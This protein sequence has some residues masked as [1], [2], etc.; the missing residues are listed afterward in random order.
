MRQHVIKIGQA[1]YLELNKR[2]S[3]IR[4]YLTE[5]TKT[6]VISFILSRLDYCNSL[7]ILIGT[8]NSII[9]PLQTETL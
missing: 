6:V 9:Q 4:Q 2:I 5:A 7:L 8:P 1:T 3:S